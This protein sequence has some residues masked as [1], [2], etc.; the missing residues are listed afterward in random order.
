[1][2]RMAVVGLGMG[3]SHGARLHKCAGVEYAA[4]CDTDPAK[5]DFRVKAYKEEIGAE[6]APYSDLAEML[7]MEKLDGVIISTPSSTHHKVAVQVADAG[8]NMLIDKPVDINGGNID[9]IQEAVDRNNVLCGVIYPMR[10]KAVYAGLKK[11]AGEAL[12]GRPVIL[13]VRLKWYRD[14]A[15][16]DKGGWRGTWAYDG[17]GSLMNQGAHPMDILCWCM[18]KPKTITGEFA[19]LRHSIE[20][21]D[22]ASGIVEFES[23]ARAT[24]TTTTCA[25]PK[26][27]QVTA[28][29]Y[30]A[31]DGSVYISNDKVVFSSLEGVD[32]LVEP[33][34]DYPVEEFVDAVAAGRQPMVPLEE[35]R[36]SVDLI[37]GVY[38]AAREGRRVQV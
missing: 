11:V 8:V 32:T 26:S 25:P 20:T 27:D 30:H 37:N 35:A 12:L 14:Q 23:G 36:W 3:G 13:D 1:M 6:P 33:P 19:A 28:F 24:V 22:W 7:R 2:L 21:E 9:R 10:C 4:M 18:G 5:L 17:G 16:Y 15:Y 29:D 31:E 34:F 38:R